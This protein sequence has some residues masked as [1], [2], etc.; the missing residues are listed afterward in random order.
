M[1]NKDTKNSNLKKL[2]EQ[3]VVTISEIVDA[4][5]FYV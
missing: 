2:N 5:E 1:F 3:K 4:S